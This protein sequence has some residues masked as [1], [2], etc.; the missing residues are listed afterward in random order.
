MIT[1]EVKCSNGNHWI[2]GINGTLADARAYFIGN[3]K[4]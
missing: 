1:V 4:A 3:E 2:T